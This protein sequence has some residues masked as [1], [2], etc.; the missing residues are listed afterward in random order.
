MSQQI[1]QEP[2]GDDFD[3]ISSIADS[4]WSVDTSVTI[5]TNNENKVKEL[6]LK[7]VALKV[8]QTF[9]GYILINVE[10]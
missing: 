7:I 10:E 4:E 8:K 5:G 1:K 6:K 3:D 9:W 2:A